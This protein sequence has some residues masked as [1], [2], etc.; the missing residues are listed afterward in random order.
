MWVPLASL[1]EVVA[2]VN[3]IRT[4]T[5][6]TGTLTLRGEGTGV[7]DHVANAG[8]AAFAFALPE[9]DSNQHASK[10]RSITRLMRETRPLPLLSRN[11]R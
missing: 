10:S 8:D 11:P 7:T 3:H 2:F 5:D 9:T 1:F 4:L 6:Q